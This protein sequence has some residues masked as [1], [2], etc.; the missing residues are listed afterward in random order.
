MVSV[1]DEFGDFG[2]ANDAEAIDAAAAE[3]AAA[4]AAVGE[5]AAVEAAAKTSAS[6]YEPSYKP[7]RVPPPSASKG[8]KAADKGERLLLRCWGIET[9]ATGRPWSSARARP[10]P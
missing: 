9:Y 4:E 6:A 7:W 2:D 5:A 8:K 3:L 1:D 10:T